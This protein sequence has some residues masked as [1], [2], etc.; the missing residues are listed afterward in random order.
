M[1]VS[2]LVLLGV[3]AL[4]VGFAKTAIG[5]F[6]SIAVAIFAL[7]LPARESTAAILLLLII[8]DV[9]AVWHYRRDA[10]LRLL[11][12]LIPAVLPGLALGALFLA[13][14]D[15]ATLRRSIGGLLLALAALQ[16]FL[17]WRAR[18]DRGEGAPGETG[19]G[20]RTGVALGTGAA[21]GFAT[22]T[23]NAAGSVMTLYLVAQ[24]VEKRRFLGTSAVFFFG[25][26]LC[27]LP[28]SAG[29]HLF[30]SQ[31]LW[32]TLALAPLVLLGTWVG[33]HTARRLTQARFDQ[34]VL[35]ATVVS[36]LALV[37]R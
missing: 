5:G 30:D 16:L 29:L 20:T 24:G 1:T 18:D 22:M 3:A 36:A 2:T 35:G 15:D 32:R 25:V 9:V 23:A 8:G 17:T 6:G 28:F 19:L 11:R 34:A 37:V 21:A 26:N 10:D 27:K 12:R 4:L 31:T 33:L 13:R 14:V 7:V